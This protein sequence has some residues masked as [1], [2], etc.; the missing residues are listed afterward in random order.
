MHKCT[1][2]CM[3]YLQTSRRLDCRPGRRV[4]HHVRVLHSGDFPAPHVRSSCAR[5]HKQADPHSDFTHART[6][7]LY[8]VAFMMYLQTSRR[9]DSGPWGRISHHVRVRNSRGFP[10]AHVQESLPGRDGHHESHNVHPTVHFVEDSL[11]LHPIAVI[12]PRE[13]TKIRE[14]REVVLSAELFE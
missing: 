11:E 13:F 7:A 6:H 9:V 1:H 12:T 5:L 10:A 2:T 4:S 14:N 8:V 3:M